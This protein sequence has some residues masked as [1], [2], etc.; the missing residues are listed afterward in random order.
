ML[1]KVRQSGNTIGQVLAHLIVTEKLEIR[2]AEV[3]DLDNLRIIKDD[4]EDPEIYHPKL[5]YFRFPDGS[6]VSFNGS[7]NESY[8]GYR[9][10]GEYI[11]IFCS[12]DDSHTKKIQTHK[13][14]LDDAWEERGRNKNY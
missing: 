13:K 5:G 7:V 8:G 2:F 12:L 14:I 9:K 6:E 3:K 4:D 11:D 1:I 10:Q